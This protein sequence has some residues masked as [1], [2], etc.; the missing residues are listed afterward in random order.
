MPSAALLVLYDRKFLFINASLQL[1]IVAHVNQD[2]N[3]LI[4]RVP[5]LHLEINV[6]LS[7]RMNVEA[8]TLVIV[9]ILKEDNDK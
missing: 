4:Q 6:A 3:G 2:A 7:S 5:P 1:L 8:V 9:K